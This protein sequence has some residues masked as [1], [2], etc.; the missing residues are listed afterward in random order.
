MDPLFPKNVPIDQKRIEC[1]ELAITRLAR[2]SKKTAKAIVTPY[3]ISN[4]IIGSDLIGKSLDGV[5]LRYLFPCKGKITRGYIQLDSKPKSG[6]SV[7]VRIFNDEV[8]ESKGFTINNRK[9]I[10][11]T[12]LDILAGDRLEVT[13]TPL[14]ESVVKEIW[15]SMLWIP[16]SG[17]VQNFLIEELEKQIEEFTEELQ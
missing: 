6:V 3:P 4:A 14:G 11:D 17:D 12:D 5:I 8:S 16:T 13:L 7:N 1:I 9:L 2:R 10:V 15:I